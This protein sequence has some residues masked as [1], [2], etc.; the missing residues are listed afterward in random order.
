MNEKNDQDEEEVTQSTTMGTAGWIYFGIFFFFAFIGAILYL[1]SFFQENSNP[2]NRQF[3]AAKRYK[4]M[5]SYL[6]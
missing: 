3:Q 4:N 5:T 6:T 1:P 2:F